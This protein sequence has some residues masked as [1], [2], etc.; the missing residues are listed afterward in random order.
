MDW[1]YSR[2][3]P[4]EAQYLYR[5][6]QEEAKFGNNESALRYLKQ[7][8]FLAPLYAKAIHEMGNCLATLGR[9][10]EAMDKY[11]LARQLDLHQAVTAQG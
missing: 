11:N 8:V 4:I 2:I 5:K 6:A 9:Y 7:A 3:I 10:D 1:L